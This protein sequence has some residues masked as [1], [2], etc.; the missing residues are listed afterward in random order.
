MSQ[1]AVEQALGKLLT[2]ESFRDRFFRNPARA[3][4][5]AGL[6]LAPEEM[7]ALQRIPVAALATLSRCLDGRICRLVLA[8]RP[9]PQE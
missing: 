9:Q 2:D 5:T 7:T 3:C 8:A 1:R 6:E 4:L